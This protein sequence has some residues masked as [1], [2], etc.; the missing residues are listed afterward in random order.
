MEG[1][2]KSVLVGKE[3]KVLYISKGAR[4]VSEGE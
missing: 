4:C 2:K 1:S 3:K